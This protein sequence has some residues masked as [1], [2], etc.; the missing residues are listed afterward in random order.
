MFV[1][2]Y[3][4]RRINTQIRLPVHSSANAPSLWF[5]MLIGCFKLNLN[6]LLSLRIAPPISCS[7]YSSIWSLLITLCQNSWQFCERTDTNFQSF[8]P[9]EM[10]HFQNC[11]IKWWR[12]AQSY[13]LFCIGTKFPLN[14]HSP[15]ERLTSSKKLKQA[16]NA[17]ALHSCYDTICSTSYSIYIVY[18]IIML[19]NCILVWFS[20]PSVGRN[21]RMAP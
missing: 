15:N 7:I 1:R 4:F 9:A 14:K 10:L 17:L 18:S 3:L 11:S 12:K 16:L 13:F 5:V 2:F 19:W 8:H 21:H 20:S 6:A